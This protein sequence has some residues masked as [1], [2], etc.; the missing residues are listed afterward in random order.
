MATF[1]SRH[2]RAHSFFFNITDARPALTRGRAFFDLVLQ[3]LL[4]WS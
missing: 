2:R 3:Q 4:I 1:A